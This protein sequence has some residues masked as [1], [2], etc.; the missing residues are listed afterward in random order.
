MTPT[1]LKNIQFFIP[2]VPAT[3]RSLRVAV[4]L[5]LKYSSSDSPQSS[6]A[7]AKW[8]TV[9]IP[10]GIRLKSASSCRSPWIK[11]SRLLIGYGHGFRSNPKTKK[12][13]C[14]RYGT[15]VRPIYPL[16]PVRRIL[17]ILT[18]TYLS[19]HLNV[20]SIEISYL[21]WAFFFTI[22]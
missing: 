14:F 6:L 17:F 15:I 4:T 16:H 11:S 1:V 2:R 10:S 5:S 19:V 18:I 20:S 3:F 12:P 21:L 22:H 13:L 7:A 8:N 9:S